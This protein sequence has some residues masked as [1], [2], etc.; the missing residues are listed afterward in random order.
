MDPILDQTLSW[1]NAHAA[2]SPQ[3]A[4]ELAMLNDLQGNILKGHG[5]TYT[6]NLFV[7]FDKTKAQAARQFVASVGDDVNAALDQLLDAEAFRKSGVSGGTF[8]AFMLTA[9]GYDALGCTNAK[10]VDEAFEKGMKARDLGDSKFT[11]WESHFAAEIHA[12]ILIGSANEG[13]RNTERDKMAARINA[14]A[15]AA[16]LLNPGFGED[17]HVMKNDDDHGIEHFGY[18]DGISQPLA[19]QEDIDEARK[20]AGGTFIWD[21]TIKL[22]QL[23]VP[24]PGGKLNVS[25][26]SFFVF[27]KLEQDVRGF[28]THEKNVSDSLTKKH[29]PSRDVDV[30]ASVIGRFENGV[31]FALTPDEKGLAVDPPNNNFDFANDPNGLKCPF[32]GHIRKSNPRSDVDKSKS[33]LM[34]RRGI[35]YGARS[36][37][38]NDEQLDNKPTGGVGLLF[39]AYQSDIAK[40]FE[41]AQQKWVNNP[42]FSEPGTGRDG[43]IGQP[44]GPSGQRWTV[45]WG[46][47]LSDGGEDEQ[48]SGFVTLKGGEYFFA[49]S[50]TFLKSLK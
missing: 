14:T 39:M 42:D 22:S 12:M 43:V 27:R 47:K 15:G 4:A 10:P 31:P 26:G 35:P 7:A 33:H 49:P 36:D 17:G 34:A 30:G 18:V 45:E 32:A 3:S 9:K 1:K 23:L 24:C 21:P 6:S 13:T 16:T 19:L 41:F 25:F 50:I 44:K 38:P 5:R 46:E 28:K 11:E 37:N 8:I 29:K 20:N 48:F 40:Q 2:V